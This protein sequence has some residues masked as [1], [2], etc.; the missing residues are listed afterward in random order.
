MK[1]R[2]VF[3]LLLLSFFKTNA[4]EIEGTELGLDLTFVASN[5]GGTVGLGSKFGIK[6][7][8]YLIAGPSV[9]YQRSWNNNIAAQ[10]KSGFNIFGGGIFAHARFFNAMFVGAEFEYLRSPY[11]SFGFLTASTQWS[12]TLF[13]GGGLSLELNESIRLNAGIMY[14]II[15][16]INSPLRSQYFMKNAQGFLLP[17]IYRIAFFFPLS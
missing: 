4:Q 11:T 10:T 14:D 9:R 6:M 7:G 13:L 17:V 12:P 1:K 15:N 8:E 5:F 3:L 16:H 2:I